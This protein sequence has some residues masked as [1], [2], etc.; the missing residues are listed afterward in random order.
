MSAQSECIRQIVLKC[1]FAKGRKT[2]PWS[3]EAFEWSTT[4]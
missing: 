2:E 4:L 1:E 3:Q